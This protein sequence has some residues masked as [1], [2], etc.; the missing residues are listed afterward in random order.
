MTVPQL[1]DMGKIPP[2]GAWNG[3][4]PPCYSVIL[5]R[6]NEKDVVAASDAFGGGVSWCEFPQGSVTFSGKEAELDS[7]EIDFIKSR[8]PALYSV[9][10]QRGFR[11]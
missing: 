8:Y 11:E 4:I 6:L 3:D 1:V 9:I 5:L 10:S 2:G 7:S